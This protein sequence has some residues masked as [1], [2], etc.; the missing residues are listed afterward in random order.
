MKLGY[1]TIVNGDAF[2]Y[3]GRT[4][5]VVHVTGGPLQCPYLSLAESANPPLFEET[6]FFLDLF[7]K[8][9]EEDGET[10]AVV[11]SGLEVCFAL[12]AQMIDIKLQRLHYGF[13]IGVLAVKKPEWI[14]FKPLHNIS[15]QRA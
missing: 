8:Q 4:A 7:T 6:E 15:I 9:A 2:A 13:T 12:T 1:S 10:T 5:S 14:F 3:Q 11:F